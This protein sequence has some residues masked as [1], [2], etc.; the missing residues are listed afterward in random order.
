[1]SSH[2]CS[3]QE[4]WHNINHH[5]EVCYKF[6]ISKVGIRWEIPIEGSALAKFYAYL[7]NMGLKYSTIVTYVAAIA[8]YHKVR[9]VVDP[10]ENFYIWKLLQEI[11]A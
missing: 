3:D 5:V 9:N 7:F 2:I 10:S 8:F 11:R 4:H 1:M 6:C